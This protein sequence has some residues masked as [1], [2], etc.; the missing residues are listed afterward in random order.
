MPVLSDGF[1]RA[2]FAQKGLPHNGGDL[3]P[4][5]CLSL[6]NP[7]ALL[8]SCLW[9]LQG[10]K[11]KKNIRAEIIAVQTTAAI[12]IPVMAP[13]E[14]WVPVADAAV[15]VDN[16]EVIVIVLVD[17]GCSGLISTVTVDIAAI[18]VDVDEA[19]V[20]VVGEG[21]TVGLSILRFV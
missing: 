21:E 16:D 14:S 17:D 2:L 20:E 19:A 3:G 4:A 15:G 9:R 18:D 10:R 12:A 8:I 13:G 1:A 11:T 7:P 6:L 5:E